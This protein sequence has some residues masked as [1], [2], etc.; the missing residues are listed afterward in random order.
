MNEA[1]VVGV[2]EGEVTAVDG[3]EWVAVGGGI[4][5]NIVVMGLYCSC[6]CLVFREKEKAIKGLV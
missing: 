4:R 3:E 5:P 6:A 2:L 1:E